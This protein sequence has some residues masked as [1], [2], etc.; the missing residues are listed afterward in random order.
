MDSS[1][2]VLDSLGLGFEFED[3]VEVGYDYWRR[4]GKQSSVSPGV[5]QAIRKNKI[6]LKGP[7][8]TVKEAGYKSAN[9]TLRQELGLFFG[10]RPSKSLWAAQPEASSAA[11]NRNIDLVFV[12]ENTEGLYSGVGWTS[13]Q[14]RDAL[15]KVQTDEET[16]KFLE[17][18]LLGNS[19]AEAAFNLRVVTRPAI[20]KI[21]EYAFS[22]AM[23][24][25]KSLVFATKANI[26]KPSDTLSEK[27]FAENA[28]R[29]P[30]V[31]AK[32]QYIDDLMQALV[33][34]PSS[35]D[36]IVTTN[37]FA[38]I[39]SD[40]AAGL[41][42]GPGFAPGANIGVGGVAGFEALHGS[43][44]DIAGQNKANPCASILSAA[45]LLEYVGFSREAEKIELAV[46]EVAKSGKPAI[47][48]TGATDTKQMTSAIISQI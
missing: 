6:C 2:R 17:K 24:R 4:S 16:K 25:K 32:I 22:L 20:E 46:A 7:T 42:G 48:E 38:D 30:Q 39:G 8:T 10:V 44:P 14:A 3:A 1:I 33:R 43:A 9:V 12:R 15:S 11:G 21:L 41:C 19:S 5:L 26:L 23:A 29:F 34:R 40:L 47:S 35:F 13:Q 45:M 27:I 18:S 36:V 31:S 37:L 28:P